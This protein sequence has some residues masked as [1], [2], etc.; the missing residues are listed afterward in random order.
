MEIL[1]FFLIVWLFIG[2]FMIHNVKTEKA[3]ENN[4]KIVKSFKEF[5]W[6]LKVVF[7]IL[8][9]ITYLIVYLITPIAVLIITIKDKLK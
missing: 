9:I 8:L 5:N 2:A 1:I 4:K 7:S 3:L 6:I